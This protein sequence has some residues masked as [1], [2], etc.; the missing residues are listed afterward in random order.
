MVADRALHLS[1][2]D[3]LGA[4]AASFPVEPAEPDAA[5]LHQLSMA[6]AALRARTAPAHPPA[7]ARRPRWA[8]PRHFSPLVLAGAAIGVVGAGTGISYAV[9]VPIPAAVRSVA[10]TVGLAQPTTPTT[11]PPAATP[12]SPTAAATAARQAESTLH[13]ALT[14]SHPAPS[15]ISHDGAVL[16]HRLAQ[17]GGDRTAAAAGAAANGQHLL[18][19]ACRQLEGFGTAGTG[20]STSHLGT[21]GATFPGCGPVGIWHEPSATTNPSS[22]VPTATTRTTQVP[23]S[24]HPGAG[25]GGSRGQAPVGGSSG[26]SSGGTRTGGSTGTTPGTSPGTSPGHDTGGSSGGHVDHGTTGGS[27]AHTQSAHTQS[28]DSTTPT[29]TYPR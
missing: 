7:A 3:L 19:Q 18:N 16:A 13:Q 27:S 8:L 17:V 4:L 22:S 28:D 24:S 26:T 15:V 14:Q 12:A 23:S 9:G 1:D 20:S 5:Q 6:V 25:T 2:E 11:L 29:A 21:G 10:R